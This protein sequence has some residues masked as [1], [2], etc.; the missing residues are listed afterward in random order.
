MVCELF[1]GTKPAARI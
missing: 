1:Q